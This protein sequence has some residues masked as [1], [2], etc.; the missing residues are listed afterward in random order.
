M[1]RE[2]RGLRG[3]RRAI[4]RAGV[5]RLGALGGALLS[6]RRGVVETLLG[7]EGRGG[8]EAR[9]DGDRQILHGRVREPVHRVRAL[10][11]A[12][13]LEREL[14]VASLRDP[15]LELRLEAQLVATAVVP[16]ALLV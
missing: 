4:A 1:A 3:L 7:D 15:V 10:E 13:Q 6:L 9:R 11:V 14:D 5:S 2:R 12:L 8:G 16:L